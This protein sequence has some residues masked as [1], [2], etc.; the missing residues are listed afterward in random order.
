MTTLFGV[1]LL[2]GGIAG[3]CSVRPED[4]FLPYGIMIILGVLLVGVG[5]V[6]FRE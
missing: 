4:N 6:W 5:L 1:A 3:G 2:V